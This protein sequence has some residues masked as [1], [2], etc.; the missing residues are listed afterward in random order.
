MNEIVKLTELN[1]EQ[2]DQAFH[3]FV[4][5]F[6]DIYSKLSK[7]KAKLRR[8]FMRSFDFS[9]AYAYVQDGRAIGFLG[10]RDSEKK[11]MN[12]D[13]E[14]FF[15]M[16]K[17]LA[18]KIAYK[19]MNAALATLPQAGPGEG[20]IDYITVSQEFRGMGVGTILIKYAQENLG[21][22]RLL[23]EV[24]TKNKGAMA[25]YKRLGFEA[26]KANSNILVIMQGLGKL[27]TMKLEC[28]RHS[29]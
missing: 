28:R 11:L 23:L 26:V 24:F 17:G 6:Y 14:A 1:E 10:I 13:K 20:Y 4:E 29:V 8:L 3:V 15:E 19:A 18:G 5:G 16:I 25:L 2:I 21:Y 22:R 12:V 7:D 27:I 9:M